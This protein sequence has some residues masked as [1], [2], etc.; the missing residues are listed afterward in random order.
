M[1][2][3]QPRAAA[4]AAPA[5]TIATIAPRAPTAPAPSAGERAALAGQ[6]AQRLHAL[7]AAHKI[8]PPQSL[9]HGEEGTVTLRIVVAGD[10]QLLDVR[11]LAAAPSRLLT[12][13]LAAVQASTPLPPL[14]AALGRARQ[15]FEVAVVYKIE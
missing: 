5:P 3:A 6:Y 13:S 15:I 1:A 11:P 10:G 7:I 4:P 9:Q 12:A 8:Y 14:P 2:P